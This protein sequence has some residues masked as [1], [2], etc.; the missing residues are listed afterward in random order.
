L[1]AEELKNGDGVASIFSSDWPESILDTDL[2]AALAKRRKT[3]T[4]AVQINGRLRF[5]ADVPVPNTESYPSTQQREARDEFIAEKL[6]ES[7]Q[8]RYWLTEKN[9]WEKR[10]KM[11]VVQEGKLVNIVF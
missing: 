11:I 8:G 1:H 7:D 6:L 9:V 3:M 4:C 10:K 2:A 5:T